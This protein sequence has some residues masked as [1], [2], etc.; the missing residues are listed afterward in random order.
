MNAQPIPNQAPASAPPKK[1]YTKGQTVS[2][3]LSFLVGYLF[4]RTF[5]ISEKPFYGFLFTFLLFA[6]G[7]ACMKR[8]EGLAPIPLK[9][10]LFYPVAAFVLNLGLFLS[11]APFLQ[12]CTF[13]GTLTCFLLFCHTASGNRLEQSAGKLYLFD[14]LKALFV[15]PFTA[16]VESF[17]IIAS[18]KGGKKLGKA[19]L[20]TLAGLGIAL[21]PTMTVLLLLSFDDNFTRTLGDLMDFLGD[22]FFSRFLSLLFGIPVGMYFFGAIC[23]RNGDT[24][25]VPGAEHCNK[26][27]NFLAFCPSFIGFVALVPLL[28]LYVVF[29]FAQK[30]YYAAVFSGTLPESHTFSSFARDGFFR[31]CAVAV[32]NALSLICLR[33]FSKKTAKGKVSPAVSVGTVLLSLVTL[34]LCGTA[35][36]QMGMYVSAYGLSRLRLYAIWFMALL[37]LFFL[38]LTLCRLIPKIPFARVAVPLFVICFALLILPDTDALIARHNYNCYKEGSNKELDVEYLGDLDDSAVPTLCEVLQNEP[39]LREQTL[40]ELK[41]YVLEEPLHLENLTLPAILAQ[42][43]IDDLPTNLRER[44]EKEV[45]FE[46]SL[47]FP[48]GTSADAYYETYTSPAQSKGDLSAYQ[49][50]RYYCNADANIENLVKSDYQ[51]ADKNDFEE[52][53]PLLEQFE[54][55]LSEGDIVRDKLIRVFDIEPD[56]ALYYHLTPRRGG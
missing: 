30:N 21:I 5:F 46:K 34:I 54:K 24:A 55:E 15:S 22:A 1:V 35:L 31:L 50:K 27:R 2:A 51:R 10:A 13:T 56:L 32:I 45:R 16:I 25:Q 8:E 12:F 11:S 33:L 4:C 43:A 53:F 17:N 39:S 20:F 19:L 26:A 28:F 3:W 9:R 49:L 38:L 40:G 7:I 18:N 29:I 52:L 41:Y 6:F 14:F 37:S 44:L 36:S 47:I 42:K 48:S 23:A